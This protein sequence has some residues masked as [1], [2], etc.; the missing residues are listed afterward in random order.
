MSVEQMVH[1]D[2]IGCDYMMCYFASVENVTFWN[3]V[4]GGLRWSNMERPCAYVIFLMLMAKL[5]DPWLCLLNIMCK[6]IGTS[7]V[8]ICD[9]CSRGW[10]M[11]CL[12]PPLGEIW[13]EKWFGP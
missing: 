2:F 8:L 3:V 4:V 13:I 11:G 5:T 7:I 12:M 1:I 10:H 6:F 9:W